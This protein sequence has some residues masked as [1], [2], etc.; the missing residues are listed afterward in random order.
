MA[1]L[2]AAYKGAIIACGG[3]KL[4]N[5][6]AIM[7]RGHADLIAIGQPYIAN[8]D[9]MARLRD[10]KELAAWDAATFYAGGPKGYTDYPVL[11]A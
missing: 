9:L 6:E 4:D 3:F 8:P 10:G 2:R 11:T 1:A 5:A 7:A